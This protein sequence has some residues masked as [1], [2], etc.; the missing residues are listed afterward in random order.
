MKGIVTNGC[1]FYKLQVFFVFSR[2][3]TCLF[4]YL[5]SSEFV[6]VSVIYVTNFHVRNL[7]KPLFSHVQLRNDKIQADELRLK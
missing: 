3:N 4:R 5:L 1:L 2:N 7:C 6:A